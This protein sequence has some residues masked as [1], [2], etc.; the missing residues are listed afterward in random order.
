MPVFDNNIKDCSAAGQWQEKYVSGS[1]DDQMSKKIYDKIHF[2]PKM[3][4]AFLLTLF[5]FYY[6]TGL[7]IR[8]VC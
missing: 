7:I 8:M 1:S 5:V 6:A 2:L 4:L 3:G